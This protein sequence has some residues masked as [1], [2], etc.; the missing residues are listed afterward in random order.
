MN[1]TIIED[2]K[3]DI[4]N[5]IF[6]LEKLFLKLKIKNHKI[7]ICDNINDLSL[8]IKNTDILFLDIEFGNLSGIDIGLSIRHKEYD[9]KIIII[10]NYSKYAIE[11]Y[12]INA[13]RYLLKPLKPEE[14]LIEM[15]P[16][17]NKYERQYFGFYDHKI[18]P[19]KIFYKDI[20]FIEYKNRKTEIHFF[21]GKIKQTTY[22]LK[23][24]KTKVNNNFFAQPHKAFIVNFEYISGFKKN[25]IVLFNGTELPLSRHY[26]NDFE[27]LYNHFLHKT[28]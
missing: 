11:G 15:I 1:I 9:C 24:W 21:N 10:T 4:Y 7:N 13:D 3:D 25:T 17:F 16:I 14:F 8:Y 28:L 26:K 5:L 27:I 23:E 20:T 19:F 12:K 2:N 18:S 6:C 22:T